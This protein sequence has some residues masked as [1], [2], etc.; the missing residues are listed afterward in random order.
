MIA[1]LLWPEEY[2]RLVGT[3]LEA[4]YPHLPAG[5]QVL[6]VEDDGRI[7]GCW[8]FFQAWHA[9]GIWI[10]PEHRGRGSVARRLLSGMRHVL[11]RMQARTVVTGATDDRVADLIARIGGSELPGRQFVVPVCKEPLR[12]RE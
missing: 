5:A 2:P 6:V 4:V 12:T 10:A 1:R 8:A 11:R 7:V 3:E 9:E